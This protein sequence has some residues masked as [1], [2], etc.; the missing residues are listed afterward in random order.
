MGPTSIFIPQILTKAELRYSHQIIACK[1]VQTVPAWVLLLV[2]TCVQ[3]VIRFSHVFAN[4][5]PWNR[6]IGSILIVILARAWEIFV[7]RFLRLFPHGVKLRALRSFRIIQTW[8]RFGPT[9]EWINKR[10]HSCWVLWT[11][12]R[13]NCMLIFTRARLLNTFACETV[14]LGDGPIWGINLIFGRMF[15]NIWCR[16][17]TQSLVVHKFSN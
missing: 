9:F 11:S 13:V 7:W 6:S 5:W 8:S 1:I 16:N 10:L 3:K 12:I 15:V 14:I 17:V 4:F 2:R